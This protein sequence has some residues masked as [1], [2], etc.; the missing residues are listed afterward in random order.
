[1]FCAASG[2]QHNSIADK[3]EKIKNEILIIAE[4]GGYASQNGQEIIFTPLP[5]GTKNTILDSL[6]AATDVHPVLCAKDNAYLTNASPIFVKKLQEY[7]TEYQLL[8][9]LKDFEGEVL[10][11]AIY[12]FESSEKTHLSLL[13]TS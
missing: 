4:N 1:M 7:Y 10:K 12:H 3:L 9:N 8:D 2:R 11:V 13:K 6:E 5:N